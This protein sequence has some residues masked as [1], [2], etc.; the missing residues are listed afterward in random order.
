MAG[1]IAVT[2]EKCGYEFGQVRGGEYS[3]CFS[4][5]ARRCWFSLLIT[6]CASSIY[7]KPSVIFPEFV[8]RGY[9]SEQYVF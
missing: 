7:E 6:G 9:R 2:G 4:C 3:N 8:W 5:I 1:Q